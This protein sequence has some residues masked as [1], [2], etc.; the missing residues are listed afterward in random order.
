MKLHIATIIAIVA[1]I[2]FTS[3]KKE[4]KCNCY[5]ASLNRNVE[6]NINAKKKDAKAE[7]EAQPITGGY[8]GSDY[9]C[10]ID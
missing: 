2:A 9:V 3:C 10:N 6:F 5:S 4:Y 1:T 8:T 7:C